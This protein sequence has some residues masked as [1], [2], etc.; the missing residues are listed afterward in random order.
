MLFLLYGDILKI[1]FLQEKKRLCSDIKIAI[2]SR[3]HSK[4]ILKEIFWGYFLWCG[5]VLDLLGLE[6][7]VLNLRLLLRAFAVQVIKAKEHLG[8]DRHRDGSIV[9]FGFFQQH[10]YLPPVI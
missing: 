6:M 3:I 5:L 8:M 9:L 4:W 7:V 10:I 1:T 2:Q